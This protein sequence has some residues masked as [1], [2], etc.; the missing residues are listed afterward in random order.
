MKMTNIR[1][2]TVFFGFPAKMKI[3]SNILQPLF[4]ISFAALE[5]SC[6]FNKFEIKK[7]LH[8]LWHSAV[9]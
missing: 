9:V 5:K 3:L 2:L 6:C 4:N 1:L 8:D 7:E